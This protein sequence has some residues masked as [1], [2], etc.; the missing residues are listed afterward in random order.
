MSGLKI[1]LEKSTLYL[2]GVSDKDKDS[3]VVQF[4]F[5]VGQLPVKCL[6]IPL[7]TKRMTSFDYNPLLEKIRSKMSSSTARYLSYDGRMHL[8]SSVITN[9][10]MSAFRLSN[11]CITEIDKPCSTFLWSGPELNARKANVAWSEVCR[12]KA[13]GSL[14]FKSLKESNIV[15]CLKL[16]WRLVSDRS[17]LWVKWVRNMLIGKEWFWSIKENTTKGSWMWRKLLKCRGLAKNIHKV[18]IWYDDWSALGRVYEVTS[19]RGVIDMGIPLAATM[20]NV[21]IKHQRRQHRVSHLNAIEHAIEKAKTEG[22]IGA[23][24]SV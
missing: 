11:G 1:S 4:P 15:S 16:I 14:G 12:P 10:W 20:E 6:G 9:L 13:E 2:A 3:I 19:A 17:S 7:L 18:E 23:D 24:I 8:L 5:A 21:F 22:K